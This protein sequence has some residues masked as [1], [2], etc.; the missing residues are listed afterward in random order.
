MGP[1]LIAVAFFIVGMKGIDHAADAA[2]ARIVLE[3]R[4]SRDLAAAQDIMKNGGYAPIPGACVV[5]GEDW[6]ELSK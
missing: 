4:A 6:E 5:H 3:D 1:L 2:R